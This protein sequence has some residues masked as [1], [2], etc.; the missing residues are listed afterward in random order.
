MDAVNKFRDDCEQIL[1][2]I[3]LKRE[4]TK[5]EVWIIEYYCKHLLSKIERR[6]PQPSSKG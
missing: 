1:A 5:E 2:A 3:E 6:L 4:P